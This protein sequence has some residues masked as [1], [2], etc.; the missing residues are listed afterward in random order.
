MYHCG[1]SAFIEKLDV[2]TH[3]AQYLFARPV[4]TD[5]WMK[6]GAC[7]GIIDICLNSLAMLYYWGEN[8]ISYYPTISKHDFF[9]HWGAV[10]RMDIRHD[11]ELRPGSYVWL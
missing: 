5:N 11:S 2:Q 1:L 4:G 9:L 7:F 10:D 3:V 8:L 6:N